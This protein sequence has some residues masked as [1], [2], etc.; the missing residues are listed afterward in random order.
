MFAWSLVVL[1]LLLIDDG[2]P[3][4][5]RL[6]YGN[7]LNESILR[8]YDDFFHEFARNSDQLLPLSFNV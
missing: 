6:F 8:R 1:L 2:F 5:I 4:L 3:W 7:G